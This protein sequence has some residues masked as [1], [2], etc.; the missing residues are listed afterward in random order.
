MEDVARAYDLHLSDRGSFGEATSPL[1]TPH[2]DAPKWHRT[3][4]I[5]ALNVL[6]HK[7]LL[8]GSL[9]SSTKIDTTHP[10][11]NELRELF[12]QALAFRNPW[13]I[14][15]AEEVAARLGNDYLGVHARVGDGAFKRNAQE[16][17]QEAWTRLVHQMD[18]SPDVRRAVWEQVKPVVEEKK[19]KR[20]QVNLEGEEGVEAR[21]EG[22]SWVELDHAFD[23]SELYYF[24][25]GIKHVVRK[26]APLDDDAT[27]DGPALQNLV[28]RAP[29]HTAP[30]LLPFNKPL[31]LA[32]DSRDPESDP[33]LAIFF[34]TFP[35][36]F[37]LN[38]FDRPNE[39]NDGDV[40]ESVQQ[41]SR[42]EN[43]NDGMPLGR[44]FLPFLEAVIAAKADIVS[45]TPGSTFSGM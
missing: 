15:P 32:T 10:E 44:L 6:P 19:A 4:S 43:E 16:N 17:M 26:R 40:V 21:A 45:G 37:V 22:S 36:T 34:H 28:C 5:G 25:E 7:V 13:L 9:F 11:A 14:R 18:V 39:L 30:E 1:I 33:A 12:D 41:M 27:A 8:V 23:E 38:D 42:L 24:D 35:C 29:L 2:S 3:V 31:Y 20:S